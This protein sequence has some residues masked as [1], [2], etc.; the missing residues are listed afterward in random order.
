MDLGYWKFEN[1]I[2]MGDTN[3]DTTEI[4]TNVMLSFTGVQMSWWSGTNIVV[5]ITTV[6]HQIFITFNIMI[7]LTFNV[8]PNIKHFQLNDYFDI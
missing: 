5:G 6:R 3:L 2:K 1:I 4:S 8:M 7:F